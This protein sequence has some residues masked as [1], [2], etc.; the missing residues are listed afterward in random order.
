MRKIHC[1]IPKNEKLA[2]KI[3]L[4]LDNMKD[5][6]IFPLEHGTEFTFIEWLNYLNQCSDEIDRLTYYVQ[7]IR[8]SKE[9]N[10]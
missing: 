7:Q 2:K 9:I 6:I 5:E 3:E 8:K 10:E 4:L 1:R